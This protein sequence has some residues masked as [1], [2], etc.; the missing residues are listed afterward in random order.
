MQ[1]II[2]IIIIISMYGKGSL[3]KN[4]K[5]QCYS[6]IICGKVASHLKTSH[7]LRC[8]HLSSMT[9]MMQCSPVEIIERIYISS[10]GE[11]RMYIAQ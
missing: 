2:I 10:E 7:A 11:T 5:L 6:T 4:C 1:Y 9:G 8:S 3:S